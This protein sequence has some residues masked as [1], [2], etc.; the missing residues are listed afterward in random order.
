M[1]Q[2]LLSIKQFKAQ[3]ELYCFEILIKEEHVT[4]PIAY[5]TLNVSYCAML[6]NG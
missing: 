4:I 6:D 5:F 3:L 2:M 1:K